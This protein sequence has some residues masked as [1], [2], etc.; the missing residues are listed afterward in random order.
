MATPSYAPSR[1]DHDDQALI[2]RPRTTLTLSRMPAP[3]AIVARPLPLVTET[4]RRLA[5]GPTARHA[6]DDA[7]PLDEDE[8]FAIWQ[9]RLR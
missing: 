3:Y 8:L 4:I 5:A 2:A 6:N 1:N 9:A 7:E